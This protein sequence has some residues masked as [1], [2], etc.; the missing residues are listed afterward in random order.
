MLAT[1]RRRARCAALSG[2]V[3][4]VGQRDGR[5]SA[6]EGCKRCQILLA[7][8]ARIHLPLGRATRFSLG[9]KKMLFCAA[10]LGMRRVASEQAVPDNGATIALAASGAGRA[11]L[12]TVAA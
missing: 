1:V 8:K 2:L 10:Q 3:R 9:A 12:S 11:L 7:L 6:E 4:A 5:V